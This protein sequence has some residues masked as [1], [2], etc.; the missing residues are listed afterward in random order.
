MRFVRPKGGVP[1]VDWHCQ[2]VVDV[3]A[4][5]DEHMVFG[6]YL[7]HC[8]RAEPAFSGRN[9]A[10][11][12]RAAKGTGQSASSGGDEVVERRGMRLMAAGLHVIVFGDLGV[13]AE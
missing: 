3:N 4:A 7:A 6:L 1:L 2:L 13:H 10:R 8:I 11:F 9:P 12:Q 5:N